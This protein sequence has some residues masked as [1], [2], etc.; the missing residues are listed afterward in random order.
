MVVVSLLE[1]WRSL[2][3][4]HD[5]CRIRLQ[6]DKACKKFSIFNAQVSRECAGVQTSVKLATNSRTAVNDS[7]EMAL[8]ASGI[9]V[10]Q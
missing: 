10:I 7:D 5:S 2:L 3:R 6:I 8:V 1:K 4:D 9:G